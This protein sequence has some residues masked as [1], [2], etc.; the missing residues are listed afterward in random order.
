MQILVVAIQRRLVA[1]IGVDRG[2]MTT[3]D[4]NR[5]IEHLGNR[6]QT[7]GRARRVG[8]DDVLRC[9]FSIIHTVNDGLVSILGRGRAQN[10]FRAGIDMGH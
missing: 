6:G 10:A 2:H 4:A 3:L 5:I 1:G 8:D 9:Q 7:I